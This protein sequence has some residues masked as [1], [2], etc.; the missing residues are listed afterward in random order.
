VSDDIDVPQVSG[1]WRPVVLLPRDFERSLSAAEQ[2]MTLGHEL[3]HLR[4]GDLAWGWVPAAAER[5]FFFHPL[6]RL[7]A[8]EYLAAREAACDAAVVAALALEPAAYGRVLV[9]LGVAALPAPA[10]SAAASSQASLR[11]RLEMLQEI[12]SRPPIRARLA[13]VLALGACV[14]LQLGARAP[15]PAAQAPAPATAPA[16]ATAPKAD[17]PVTRALAPRSAPQPAASANPVAVDRTVL[18]DVGPPATSPRAR[19]AAPA[20]AAQSVT[21][22]PPTAPALAESPELAEAIKR[23][24][25]LVRELNEAAAAVPGKAKTP[26]GDQVDKIRALQEQ[27]QLVE[28]EKMRAFAENTRAAADAI[29]LQVERRARAAQLAEVTA[30]L[31]ELNVRL[32]EI[33]EL[34]TQLEQQAKQLEDERR[35]L[36][37]AADRIR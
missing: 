6:A 2:T 12:G 5:L 13:L 10:A 18:R 34:R 24:E 11:R 36:N 16:S 20:T 21:A 33:G 30:R 8:R 9:R 3:V 15:E 4:R 29:R 17:R 28:T 14:P 26:L 7:A 35:R 1:V 23:M 32:R 22:Q 31:D 27:L 37:E 25:A 19:A